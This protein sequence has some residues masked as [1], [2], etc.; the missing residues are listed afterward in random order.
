MATVNADFGTVEYRDGGVIAI[1]LTFTET[2]V[3]V[4]SKSICRVTHVSGSELTGVNYRMIGKGRAF[5]TVVEMPP[6]RKGSFSVAI[7]GTVLNV[8]TREWDSVTV[9]AKTV[10]YNTTVPEI[11]LFDIPASYT[12]TEKFDVLLQF[13]VPVTF[14]PA[15]TGGTFL[16]HFI[17]EGADLGTPNLY[18]SSGNTL[19]TEL[20]PD[21][22]SDAA[23]TWSPVSSTSSEASIYLLRW[24]EVNENAKGV[25]NLTLR[26]GRVRGPVS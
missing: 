22:L 18:A 19:P 2:D 5:E 6:N 26:P 20:L 16:D 23:D 7:T 14:E 9:T 4:P 10:P 8:S 1:P 25:F 17:F 21:D 12:P 24:T 13:N 11:M 3:I 15:P